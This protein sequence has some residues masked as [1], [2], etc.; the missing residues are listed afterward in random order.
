[1]SVFIE[2]VEPKPRLFVFGAGTIGGP[3]VALAQS[4]GFELTVVDGREEWA[5][6][7][8]FPG[9][10]V[11]CR[12]PE[13]AAQELEIGP[14]DYACVV[15]HDHALDGQVVRILIRRPLGFLGMVGS[16]AK[17]RAFVGRLRADGA[18]DV[19]LARLRTP[20]GLAI[21]ANTPEEIAVSV[22]AQLIAA[23]R[24]VPIEAGWERPV[25]GKEEAR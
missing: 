8:R 4:C 19:E 14:G 11:V 23:R 5:R 9:A 20:L 17:Q 22:V 2:A 15:T 18:T 25:P 13:A 3:L 24:G 6:P 10:S 12:D 1:M 21:G 7:E 16:R